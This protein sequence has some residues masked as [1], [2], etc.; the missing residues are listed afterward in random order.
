MERGEARGAG[1][2]ALVT[3][4]TSGIG[5]EIAR[6]LAE[7]GGRV[8]LTGRDAG[9]GAAAVESL[10]AGGG[11]VEWVALD[12]GDP[13]A[14]ARAAAEALE[15]CGGRIDQLVNNAGIAVS[16]PLLSREE[17]YERHMQVNFHG[18]RRLIEAL[19]PAMGRAGGGRI[20]NVASSAGLRGYAYAA[21]YCASKH[22]LVGYSRAAAPELARI[23]VLLNVV[24]PHY[25]D[26]P[27]TARSVERIAQ[28]TGRGREEAR[29]FLESQN[30]GGR[31]VRPAE[32]ADAVVELLA[33]GASGRILELDGSGVRVVEPG[34]AGA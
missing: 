3:G 32:V 16:A 10:R 6:R 17:L 29:R 2:S 19:A 1:S 11:R 30:P 14:P 15:L 33:G 20:V 4:A 18:A 25:A 13:A 26:T 27:M 5:L 12:L 21:A 7:G 23:G 24:C 34:S 31:L 22:A 28:K 8:I 9:R